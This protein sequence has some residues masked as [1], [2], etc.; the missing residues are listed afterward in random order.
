MAVL[1]VLSS[2]PPSPGGAP[3]PGLEEAEEQPS[4]SSS[5][6]QQQPTTPCGV[7]VMGSEADVTPSPL[8]CSGRHHVGADGSAATDEDC[9]VKAIWRTAARNLDFEGT[10]CRK[11]FM[12]FDNSKVS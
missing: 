5:S 11:S 12:S 1:H 9:M 7:E 8:R 4:L 3:S 10:P 6:S 2:T